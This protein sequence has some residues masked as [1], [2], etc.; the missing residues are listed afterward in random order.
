MQSMQAG[1]R[2]RASQTVSNLERTKKLKLA[3]KLAPP[4]AVDPESL[5]RHLTL[6]LL[7]RVLEEIEVRSPFF[8]EQ[9][10]E[11]KWDW[12]SSGDSDFTHRVSLFLELVQPADHTVGEVP[13]MFRF[14]NRYRVLPVDFKIRLLLATRREEVALD[15]IINYF[16]VLPDFYRILV[17]KASPVY[18][19]A[20]SK[21]I[22]KHAS[23]MSPQERT[24]FIEVA[25][26]NYLQHLLTKS[27]DVFT[28]EE[29]KLIQ[30]R[31]RLAAAK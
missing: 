2:A 17:L 11:E 18:S 1:K 12:V 15:V 22:W 7:D 3:F 27:P 8:G 23:H 4:Q 30:E 29:T 20:L 10:T 24:R 25:S 31:L 19:N 28:E 5:E 13:V 21:E 16:H 14:T 6:S 9:R 26:K